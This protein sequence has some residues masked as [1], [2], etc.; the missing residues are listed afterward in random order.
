MINQ[1]KLKKQLTNQKPEKSQLSSGWQS[2]SVQESL[3]L[4][5]S[6]W[7]YKDKNASPFCVKTT[8]ME[9][10]YSGFSSSLSIP[11]LILVGF[12]LRCMALRQCILKLNFLL[13]E[14]RK[15]ILL[16]LGE[17]TGPEKNYVSMTY[18]KIK[19]KKGTCSKENNE[20]LFTVSQRQIFMSIWKVAVWLICYLS[21][22]WSPDLN[23]NFLPALDMRQL[24]PDRAA[25]AFLI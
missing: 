21:L 6:L 19:N 23:E 5:P 22:A 16:P 15:I 25:H 9:D 18:I 3:K 4:L 12:F 17:R 7:D 20:H 13:P 24:K 2:Y 14:N 11:P 10:P 8:V 1:T